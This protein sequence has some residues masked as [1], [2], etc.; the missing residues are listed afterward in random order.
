M[1]LAHCPRHEGSFAEELK[2]S[3]HL[4]PQFRTES[5]QQLDKVTVCSIYSA[6]P[7]PTVIHI[8]KKV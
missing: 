6:R 4:E 1:V 8:G 7:F 5:L 2:S 3:S